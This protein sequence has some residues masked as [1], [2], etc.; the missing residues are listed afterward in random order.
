VVPAEQSISIPKQPVDGGV[1]GNPFIWV[2]LVDGRNNALTSMIYLGRCVQGIV[3]VSADFVMPVTASAQFAADGCYN[4]PGPNITLAGVVALTG[5][6]AR[7]LFANSDNRV[8]G[9]HQNN[10]TTNVDVVV[11]PPGQAIQIPK[12]PVL[13]GVGGNPWISVLFESAAGDPIGG[14]FLLGRCVQL[15]K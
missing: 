5:V 9:P 10:Q 3:P 11:V 8:G 14:E 7:F 6:K 12:Q 2:Q 4:N 1:G 15:S 13:G